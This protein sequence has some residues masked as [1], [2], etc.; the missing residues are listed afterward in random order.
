MG[1]ENVAFLFCS[2]PNLGE[3]RDVL[4]RHLLWKGMWFSQLRAR[5][6]DGIIVENM[7]PLKAD[8]PQFFATFFLGDGVKARKARKKRRMRM[9]VSDNDFHSGSR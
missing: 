3:L 2:P 1:E 8:D 7:E 6:S 5:S 4:I 9:I